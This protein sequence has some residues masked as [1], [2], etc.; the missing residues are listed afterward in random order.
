MQD[1]QCQQRAGIGQDHP[2]G[3][4]LQG[5]FS[6]RDIGDDDRCGL[7][8]ADHQQGAGGQPTAGFGNKN[9]RHGD[10]WAWGVE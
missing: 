7:Y 4:L 1:I 3:G 10:P 9:G 6:T 5:D 2:L 8:G